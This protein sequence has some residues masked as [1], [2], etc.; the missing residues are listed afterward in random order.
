[1]WAMGYA[2]LSHKNELHHIDWK[3]LT[4]IVQ[5][6]IALMSEFVYTE[7]KLHH[8]LEGHYSHSR[9]FWL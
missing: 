9:Q 7:Y 3:S 8:E 2:T 6:N 5:K 4:N 1:M